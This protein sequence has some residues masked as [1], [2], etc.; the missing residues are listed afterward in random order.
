[1]ETQAL[2]NAAVRAQVDDHSRRILVTLAGEVLDDDDPVV[3]SSERELARWTGLSRSTVWNRLH[4]LEDLGWLKAERIP[5][6][7]TIF[8]LLIPAGGG[9]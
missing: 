1:M 9:I 8:T 4:R 5:G 7:R 2:W 3:V 6:A